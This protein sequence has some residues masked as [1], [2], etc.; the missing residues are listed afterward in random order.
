MKILVHIL[1]FLFLSTQ[2]FSQNTI[3]LGIKT[4]FYNSNIHFYNNFFPQ[5]IK[6]SSLNNI[7]LSFITEIKN[8]R[9]TGIRIEI[10]KIKKGWVF[11]EENNINNNFYQSEFDF[12][13]IPFMMTTY[14]GNNKFNINFAL[15]PFAEFMIS[16]NSEK[17]K[18]NFPDEPFYYNQERDN[19]FSYG[20]MAMGGVSINLNKNHIQLLVSYQY[21]FDNVFDIDIKNQ[22][23]PDISNFNT[24]SFSLVY[25][26]S[27]IKKR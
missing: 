8:E 17:I 23:I 18:L 21:N 26:R 4:S 22:T 13:N 2:L 15:G 27:I 10:S 1:F 24:L 20:L 9:N 14:F 16:E 7:N 11:D 19:M 25:L 3:S 5:N 6:T 12:I